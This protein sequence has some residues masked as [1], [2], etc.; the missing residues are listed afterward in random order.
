MLNNMSDY[1]LFTD[2]E[3]VHLLKKG[4]HAAFTEIY[5]RYSKV[6]YI[7]AY[8]ILNNRNEVKDIVQDIFA[9]L[10]NKRSDLII[11]T[12]LAGYL[13]VATR[14]NVIKIISRQQVKSKYLDFSQSTLNYSPSITDHLIREKQLH[15][16]IEAEINELPPKMRLIINLSRKSHLTHKEIAYKLNLSEST[17]KKQVNNSLKILRIKLQAYF[18]LVL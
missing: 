5:I 14:N 11:Q 18:L 2:N 1:E 15:K 10:W 8:K 6:L 3:L 13:Y 9:T 16:I 17:V 4:D 12:N 7:H